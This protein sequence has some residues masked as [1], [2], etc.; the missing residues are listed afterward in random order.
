MKDSITLTASDGH[1]FEAYLAAPAGTAKGAVVVIQEIFG[2]NTHIKEVTDRMAAAGYLVIAPAL[3]DRIAPDITL[4]YDGD[5]VAD[6]DDK[7]PNQ[8]GPAANNGCP[9]KDSDGDGVLDK[10]DKCPNEA[11]TVAN[12]GCPEISQ[13]AINALDGY[14]KTILFNTGKASF[15]KQTLPVLVSIVAIL[16]ENPTAKFT[17]SGHTDSVGNAASNLKLSN[18]RAAAVKNYLVSNGVAAD[19]LT[20][21]GFGDTQPIDNNTT[22]KGKANNRRVEVKYVK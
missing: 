2:V 13:A 16:K 9:W 20:S 14:A 19:R 10:D 15:Q 7:C 17:I 1:S 3:F 22:S 18:G 21:N 5:G 12:N 6:G 8:A 4:A 11:G